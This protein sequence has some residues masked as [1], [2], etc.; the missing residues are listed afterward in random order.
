M[1]NKN[2]IKIYIV[3]ANT[4]LATAISTHPTKAMKKISKKGLR[5]EAKSSDQK[6]ITPADT[7]NP[8]TENIDTITDDDKASYDKF[9]KDAHEYCRIY[10]KKKKA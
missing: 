9:T 8:N 4:T 2:W 7:E 3:I 10:Y 5:N 1:I 6:T